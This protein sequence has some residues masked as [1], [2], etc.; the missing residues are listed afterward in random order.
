MLPAGFS[1]RYQVV[2]RLFSNT[3][4]CI[5]APLDTGHDIIEDLKATPCA[6]H[7]YI[8]GKD[9]DLIAAPWACFYG[10]RRGPEVG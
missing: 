1:S 3:L 4:F 10:E 5:F 7:R 8:I 2:I 6:F 9:F